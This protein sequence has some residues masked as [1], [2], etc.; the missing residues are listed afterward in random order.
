ML[1]GGDKQ[2]MVERLELLLEGYE[3]FRD[4]DNQE[5]ILIEPLRSLRMIHY[6]AWL[7]RRWTD[8]SFQHHFP[9][10]AEIRYWEQQILGLKEQLAAVY[11]PPIKSQKSGNC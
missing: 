6:S 11:D 4:F 7:S 10:F 3:E 8:P 1:L 5:L 2:T 9:W